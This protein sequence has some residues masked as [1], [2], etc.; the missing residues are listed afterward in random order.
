MPTRTIDGSPW[1]PSGATWPSAKATSVT[2]ARPAGPGL[3]IAA[4]SPSNRLAAACAG[5]D[6]G[7][8]EPSV[9]EAQHASHRPGQALVVGRHHERGPV[10]VVEL[11]HP[12]LQDRESVV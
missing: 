10:L 3:L 2:A 7:L 5:E 4:S 9:G 12:L 6:D 1:A 11:E 8:A